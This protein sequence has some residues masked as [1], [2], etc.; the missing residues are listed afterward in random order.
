MTHKEII[1]ALKDIRPGSEWTLS[2][3]DFANLEWLDQE[4][5]KPTLAEI[6]AAI[7]SP[8]PKPKPTVADK[9]AA[10]GINLDELKAALLLE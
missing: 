1:E 6:E 7:A 4:A 3:D 9:L 2:G 5:T 8:L 10:A